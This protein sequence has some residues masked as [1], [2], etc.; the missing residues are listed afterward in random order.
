MLAALSG[1]ALMLPGVAGAASAAAEPRANVQYGHYDEE[2]DRITTDVYHGDFVLPVSDYFEFTFSF[3]QDTYSGATPSY[4]VPSGIS[5]AVTAASDID[6]VSLGLRTLLLNPRFQAT[7]REVLNDIAAGNLPPPQKP[8]DVT[9][10][11]L[12]RLARQPQ[13][14]LGKPLQV[15]SPQPLETRNQPVLGGNFYLG[16]ATLSLSGGYSL[17]PDFQATFGSG[18]L[19]L[20]LND[21]LTTLSAGYSQSN[22]KII[23]K[24]VSLGGPHDHSSGGKENF[25]ATSIYRTINL[26]LTQ[27]LDKNTLFRLNGGYSWRRGFLSNPYKLVYIKD[28]ITLDEFIQVSFIDGAKDW[29]SVTNLDVAGFDLFREVRPDRRNQWTVSAGLNHYFDFLDASLHFDYRYFWDNWDIKSHTFD[30]AW[31]QNLP[32]GVTFT[33]NFRYYSQ[34]AAFFYAPFY[35]S[36]RADG[37]YS[38]DYRLSG[39]GKIRAG[40]TFSKRFAKGI[41]LVAGFEYSIHKGSLKLGGGGEKDYAD[42]DSYLLHAGLR[43]ALADFSRN[44]DSGMGHH[45]RHHHAWPV[46]AGVMFAHMLPA[47]NDFMVSYNYA[48]SNMSSGMQ[49]SGR[50]HV[51]DQELIDKACDGGVCSFI[52]NRMVMHMHML[53]FMYAPTSWLNLMVMPQFVHKKM[54]MVPLPNQPPET[55]GGDHRATG[56]GDTLLI[57]LVK[58]FDVDGHHAHLGL[59]VSA[60]TGRVDITFNGLPDARDNPIQSFGMQLGSGTWDFKPSLTYT[61]GHER[62]YWGAQVNATVRLEDRNKK[63]YALG[64]EIQGHVWGGYKVMDWLAFSVRNSYR[65][66]GD[67]RGNIDQDV[68]TFAN[69]DPQL[70]PLENPRNWGGKFWDIGVGVSLKA[71]AGAYSGHHLSVEWL[72]PVIHNLN[73]YQLQRDGTLLV[74]WGYHF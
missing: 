68:P 22:N 36:P 73:G 57:A 64:N 47:A 13:G 58:L 33:P 71:P 16:P 55:E 45:H 53:N 49:T 41:E 38:S 44:L 5:D 46:P 15:M 26:G 51:S 52:P 35:L 11:I 31:Y 54:D 28:E 56:L 37:F 69:G 70:T 14:D 61:G 6:P 24:P 25:E 72:Q 43:M 18:N 40:L 23:R 67:V 20:E 12:R 60:P 50:H 30:L 27:V 63:G 4:T 9:K 7:S 66:T 19:S 39:F 32:F 3:D 65:V 34:S 29:S 62:W 21:K 1:A 8:T 2:G 42:I 59:G 48:Y 74:R 10:E 17:E